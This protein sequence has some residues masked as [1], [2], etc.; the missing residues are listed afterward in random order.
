MDGFYEKKRGLLALRDRNYVLVKVDV[1]ENHPN[2]D[3]LS[4]F[5]QT[6]GFPHIF[7]LNSSGR[8]LKSEGTRQLEEGD[9]YNLKRF[10]QFLEKYAARK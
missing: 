8:L 7:I 6:Q 5:P 2:A 3:F 10:T 4:R 9:S 1:S